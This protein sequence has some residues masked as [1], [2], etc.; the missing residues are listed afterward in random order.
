GARFLK[1]PPLG[2]IG[3]TP[4]MFSAMS[5]PRHPPPPPPRSLLR[6]P[7]TNLADQ[8][9]HIMAALDMALVGF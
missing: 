9:S 8:D 5:R 7:V 3:V 6:I 2:V 1:Y 4:T